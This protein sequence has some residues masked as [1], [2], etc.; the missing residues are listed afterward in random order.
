M[1]TAKINAQNRAIP[2]SKRCQIFGARAGRRLKESSIPTKG[3]H[4]IKDKVVPSRPGLACAKDG[5]RSVKK[6]ISKIFMEILVPCFQVVGKDKRKI[7]IANYGGG[8]D[9]GFM[10][11]SV[12]LK[13]RGPCLVEFYLRAEGERMPLL[14]RRFR[15]T[16]IISIQ[17]FDTKIVD[18]RL[19]QS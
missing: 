6:E 13:L 18:K 14:N 11:K 19:L 4:H 5:V 9:E 1:G 17:E 15:G 8:K 12:L 7:F 10:L 3:R 2:V 16:K